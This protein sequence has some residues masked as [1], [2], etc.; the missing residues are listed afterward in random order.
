[1]K[2]LLLVLLFSI[3][4][5]CFFQLNVFAIN[6]D[7]ENFSNFNYYTLYQCA[8]SE[9]MIIS[10]QKLEISYNPSA[11]TYS[12][13]NLYNLNNDF[14]VKFKKNETNDWDMIEFYYGNNVIDFEI[15]IYLSNYDIYDNADN[16]LLRYADNSGLNDYDT[17]KIPKFEYVTEITCSSYKYLVV[18]ESK[19]KLDTSE[20]VNPNEKNW[21]KYK[22]TDK[23]RISDYYGPGNHVLYSAININYSNYDLY[24]TNGEIE[25]FSDDNNVEVITPIKNHEYD[26]CFDIDISVLNHGYYGFVVSSQDGTSYYKDLYN[27]FDE[28]Y[29]ANAGEHININLSEFS[30]LTTG[31]YNLHVINYNEPSGNTSGNIV[32]NIPFSLR[33]NPIIDIVPT[34]QSINVN[35]SGLQ[36]M[37]SVEIEV[38]E[39][40]F[41]N[42]EWN[43]DTME[44]FIMLNTDNG[45]FEYKESVGNKFSLD[46]YYGFEVLGYKNG[47]V[48]YRSKTVLPYGIGS[49]YHVLPQSIDEYIYPVES[50]K[51]IDLAT[52]TIE[53]NNYYGLTWDTTGELFNVEI[54]VKNQGANFTQASVMENGED[55]YICSYSDTIE[56]FRL[57]KVD[58]D[59]P[60]RYSDWVVINKDS[61]IVYHG[62]DYYFDN[63]MYP[64]GDPLEYDDTDIMGLKPTLP[65]SL[66]PIDYIKYV[67]NIISWFITYILW[68][69]H[70]FIKKIGSI[71]LILQEI[72]PFLPWEVTTM[73][74][75]GI[76][77]SI[78]L[79]L[80]GKK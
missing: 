11:G 79:R 78:V 58:K 55:T 31:N 71:P 57:R 67:F 22:Y 30:S 19:L 17:Y 34:K 36:S 50:L 12:L 39:Y 48:A 65:N 32:A 35:Y 61:S 25:H 16:N 2:K 13:R 21:F 14:Y 42:M 77:V 9:Y 75:G 52:V 69:I 80:F 10:R 59:N 33:L 28:T 45:T 41:K 26:T 27:G 72:I 6:S 38:Y 3:V 76:A 29:E 8:G 73:L 54:Q 68:T 7:Y 74:S 44:S 1:M 53:G 4:F 49:K 15:S 23:Y 37:N 51:N 56:S 18:S 66:N 24:N 40:D 62:N 63:G 5:N 46:K 64:N 43:Q 47:E 70:T 20:I 60:Q